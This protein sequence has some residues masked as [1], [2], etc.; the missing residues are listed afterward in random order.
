[1]AA[2][3]HSSLL[4]G[5]KMLLGNNASALVIRHGP[6]AGSPDFVLHPPHLT[7]PPLVM[8]WPLL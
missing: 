8:G 7:D 1:M 4:P 3:L 2:D 6:V 5:K